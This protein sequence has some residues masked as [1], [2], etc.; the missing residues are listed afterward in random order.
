MA[1]P[2]H[3]RA[4]FVTVRLSSESLRAGNWDCRSSRSCKTS[5]SNVFSWGR[6]AAVYLG[7]DIAGGYFSAIAIAVPIAQLQRRCAC[8]YIL[9]SF[10][11]SFTLSNLD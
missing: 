5:N 1:V 7:G 2:R 6:R 10:N 3:L 9:F 8:I 4:I 11:L